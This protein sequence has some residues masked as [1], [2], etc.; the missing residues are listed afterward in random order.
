MIDFSI[1]IIN[2]IVGTRAI[3]LYSPTVVTA[4]TIEDSDQVTQHPVESG[5]DITDH[6]LPQNTHYSIECA[7]AEDIINGISIREIYQ[8]LLDLRASG[9]PFTIQ[10]GKKVLNNMLF[11]KITNTTDVDSEYVLKLSME[12]QQVRLV[13]L[14]TVALSAGAEGDATTV[15]SGKKQAQ[16]VSDTAVNEGVSDSAAAN[17]PAEDTS[18]L[19]DLA[20]M[21]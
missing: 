13:T 20:N 17:A 15:Q 11:T 14:Q 10:A 1:S 12:F 2:F 7:W 16:S 3:G 19:Y 4:E 8:Q 18:A 5:A 6:V 21:F 9:K